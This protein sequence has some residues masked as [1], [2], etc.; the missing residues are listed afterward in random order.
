[1]LT[2][3]AQSMLLR[4]EHYATRHIY[5]LKYQL[6][7]HAFNRPYGGDIELAAVSSYQSYSS[8]PLRYD[9]K[10]RYMKSLAIAV[11]FVS[12]GARSAD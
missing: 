7:V 1:M 4:Q 6:S 5:R 2:K 9:S 8:L 11:S 12:N 3:T 10:P